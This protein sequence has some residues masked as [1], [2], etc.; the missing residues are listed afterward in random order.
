MD[1]RGESAIRLDID[2]AVRGIGIIGFRAADRRVGHAVE[3]QA[4]QRLRFVSSGKGGT[5]GDA[6]VHIRCAREHDL[7]FLIG[8]MGLGQQQVAQDH[9]EIER[10]FLFLH[11]ADA[12]RIVGAAAAD[13]L[14][15]AMAGVENDRA[16]IGQGGTGREGGGRRRIEQR[17]RLGHQRENVVGIARRRC[18][19]RADEADIV[20]GRGDMRFPTRIRR[21]ADK[22]PITR[23]EILDRGEFAIGIQPVMCL[24]HDF[25]CEDRHFWPPFQPGKIIMK[26]R[27]VGRTTTTFH[28]PLREGNGL[29][30]WISN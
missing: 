30:L 16:D 24:I 19:D 18:V 23:N 14:F 11:P 6:D 15:A 7:E 9:A 8:G 5:I 29:E 22:G 12:H 21:A 1:R 4:D 13:L 2:V 3:M 28:H 26:C 20:R 27:K 10:E 25:F 17:L